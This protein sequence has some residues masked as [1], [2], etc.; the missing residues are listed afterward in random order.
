MER[1]VFDPNKFIIDGDVCWIVLYNIKNAEIARTK[2]D[3]KYKDIIESSKLKWHLKNGYVATIW[4]DD[5]C[6]QQQE[7]LHQAIVQLSGQE[8]P[9][10]KEIDHK[11]GDKLNNLETNLRICKHSENNKNM[12]KYKNNISGYKCVSWYKRAKK[13]E[14]YITVNGKQTH[15]GLFDEPKDA[16]KAYNAAAIKYFGEFAVL[17]E[18]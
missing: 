11:D 3:T 10:E 7:S 16:A 12:K 2:I 14:A 8:V 5:N 17:N 9:D 4:Y 6:K 18:V 13:W 15:L 1:T